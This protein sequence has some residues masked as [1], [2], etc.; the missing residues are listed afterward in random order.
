MTFPLGLLAGT[1]FGGG[2]KVEGQI[3]SIHGIASS[4]GYR[5][6]I[7]SNPISQTVSGGGYTTYGGTY[8]SAIDVIVTPPSTTES[9]RR[10]SSG[11]SNRRAT[12][13]PAIITN[14][15][16]KTFAQIVAETI[17]GRAPSRLDPYPDKWIDILDFNVIMVNWDKGTGDPISKRCG[18]KI[19]ADI[20]CDGVVDILDF[21]LLM[22]Y[23]G[24]PF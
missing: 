4:T 23:W 5:S 7:G 24:K 15:T 20:N 10:R 1:Q 17:V 14:V 12:T 21:N 22:V 13:T 18:D 2:Y 19:L 6:E 3:N 16:D 9:P 8:F 11:D